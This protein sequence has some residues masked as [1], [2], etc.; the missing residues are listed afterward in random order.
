M[1]WF[2]L[3]KKRPPKPCYLA[4]APRAAQPPARIIADNADSV[5][6]DTIFLWQFV[7]RF[8]LSTT[9]L[10]SVIFSIIFSLTFVYIWFHCGCSICY[11]LL[12]NLLFFSVSACSFAFLKIHKIN[13]TR[14]NNIIVLLKSP[15]LKWMNFNVFL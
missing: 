10:R 3:G 5:L 14:L 12:V 1:E 6:L 13:F 2:F 9:L 7:D 4:A 11:F 15:I 8:P